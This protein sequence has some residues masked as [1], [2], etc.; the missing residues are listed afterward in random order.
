[1]RTLIFAKIHGMKLVITTLF[2]LFLSATASAY[3]DFIGYGYASCLTCHF[4]GQGSGPLN[5]Y[6][7]ALWSAEIASRALY[8]KSKSDEEI[9]AQSG[10]LGPVELPYW[11]RPH[12]KY[13]DLNLK[14]S[15]RSEN[16]TSM[17]YRMQQEFGVALSDSVGKYVAVITMS[18]LQY[19]GEMGNAKRY[20]PKEYY[21]R[22]EIVKTWWI[23]VGLL[24]RVYGIRNIDHSSYQRT[25]QGFNP[26]LDSQAGNW[27][28]Q[29]VVIQKIEDTW[30]LNLNGFIG[31]PHMKEDLRH[32]GFSTMG[33]FEVGTNKRLGGSFQAAKS[34][35]DK[36]DLTGIHY[37][38]GFD[39]GSSLLLEYGIIDQ[40]TPGSEKRRGS[41]NFAQTLIP[42]KRGYNFKLTAERYNAEFKPSI[43]DQWRWMVGIL[44]FPLP[45]LELRADVINQRSFS[46]LQAPDDAWAL[47]G[48]IHVS[49]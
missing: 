42:I 13:R 39:G 20:L 49:L 12:I 1:M 47:Q 5:D 3:P 34:E 14:R 27:F 22:A 8:P 43:P 19:S 40:Q 16:E 37:R 33:E 4:N 30:E 18:N 38:Q 15:F 31:N 45:R 46:D 17:F 32:K 28:S 10:F 6:G 24:E 21:L 7:R 26:T 36:R 25:W 2:T 29:G 48:Q 11:I 35:L 41:Y 9:A 23:Y 44:A